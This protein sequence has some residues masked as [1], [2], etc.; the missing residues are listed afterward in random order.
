MSELTTLVKQAAELCQSRQCEEAIAVL[1]QAAH[2][3]PAS[4]SLRYELGF[5]YSGGC[6]QHSL[7][8]PDIALLHLQS[9]RS[10]ASASADPLLCARILDAM[11]NVYPSVSGLS[12][13]ARLEAA[14]NCHH[15]A[16]ALYR[17]LAMPEDWAREQFNQ[18]NAWCELPEEG[19]SEKWE[20]AIALYEGAL[21]VR[22]KEKAPELYAAT[23]QNLGTACRELCSGERGRNVRKAIHCYHEALHIR[24]A[25]SRW[26]KVAALHHNLGNA[27]LTLAGIEKEN[28][29][30][31]AARALR[32]FDHSMQLYSQSNHPCDCSAIQLGREQAYMLLARQG[33]EGNL[34]SSDVSGPLFDGES[35]KC[36]IS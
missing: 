28:E 32:H 23:M 22:T 33:L 12:Q 11:G 20:Q 29:V 8:D 24:R 6:C 5:C 1:E 34:Q 18:G 13:R 4:P 10:Q 31:H 30:H 7:C 3:D 2:L 27:F 36:S 26:L 16:A 25:A 17:E 19:H 15:E 9:A 21:Q 14:I 35:S